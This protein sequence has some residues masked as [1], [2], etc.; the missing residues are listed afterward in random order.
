MEF[1]NNLCRLQCSILGFKRPLQTEE[2][3][4]RI[5]K[6]FNTTE[7]EHHRKLWLALIINVFNLETREY[8]PFG[9][10]WPDL[11]INSDMAFSI[12]K[13]ANLWQY[14]LE[15]VMYE[16]LAARGL[17]K[18]ASSTDMTQDLVFAMAVSALRASRRDH[19]HLPDPNDVMAL[20]ERCHE[21]YQVLFLMHAAIKTRDDPSPPAFWTSSTQMS[22]A[23]VDSSIWQCLASKFKQVSANIDL[24]KW[25]EF[26]DVCVP[27]VAHVE[28]WPW[29]DH[30]PSNLQLLMAHYAY[31][32]QD[33]LEV[34]RCFARKY[35][36]TID[37]NLD[38]MN[39][40]QIVE[41]ATATAEDWKMRAYF[42]Q[43]LDHHWQEVLNDPKAL[44]FVR[45]TAPR[46]GT[47]R[48]CET[49][50]EAVVEGHPVQ[51]LFLDALEAVGDFEVA[52]GYLVKR[53][54]QS[55]VDFARPSFFD[56]LRAYLN[57]VTSGELDELQALILAIQS[58]LEMVHY[59]ANEAKGK[60]DVVAHIFQV[61]MPVLATPVGGQQTAF[62]SIVMEREEDD[63]LSGLCAKI[64]SQSQILSQNLIDALARKVLTEP[65]MKDLRLLRDS[66]PINELTNNKHIF[67][68]LCVSASNIYLS[69]D[70]AD[71]L[72]TSIEILTNFKHSAPEIRLLLHPDLR[73]YLSQKPQSLHDNIKSG[74]CET[75]VNP[76]Q[77]LPFIGHFLDRDWQTLI[78]SCEQ[79]EFLDFLINVTHSEPSYL[80]K[81]A[82]QFGQHLKPETEILKRLFQLCSMGKNDKEALE[83]SALNLLDLYVKDMASAR[84]VFSLVC[85]LEDSEAKTT[86]LSKLQHF[87]GQN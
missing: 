65:T 54:Q 20:I 19:D 24:E 26:V 41:K 63:V 79:T 33:E 16:P 12:A 3:L 39:V 86:M 52:K 70:K 82:R 40:Q 43:L 1:D 75:Q 66:V 78:Q 17:I 76:V 72:E 69:S 53:L 46:F 21:M 22:P 5:I 6:V 45:K 42:N 77:V 30:P 62:T 23:K 15:T 81:I 64:C 2:K 10:L 9:G 37:L 74:T 49:L 80:P 50:F 28:L 13:R 61:I 25:M 48:H 18:T 84:L 59:L 60:V 55:L 71:C 56:D 14:L 31:L 35:D 11:P 27:D 85:A 58:P 51:C 8:E 44:D 7:R 4:Q 36:R 67:S 47:V 29:D 73:P 32:V 34:V 87:C 68:C 57:K 83:I 38:E